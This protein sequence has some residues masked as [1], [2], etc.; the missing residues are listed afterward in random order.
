MAIGKPPI[1]ILSEALCVCS[2]FLW[3][4][5]SSWAAESPPEGQKDPISLSSLLKAASAQ[6]GQIQE[7]LQDIEIARGQLARAKAA[8]FPKASALVLAAPIFE[9]KGNA[10]ASTSNYSTW[11]P[12]IKG[13]I[14]IAQPLYTFGQISSYRK[15][16]EHQIDARVELASAKKNEILAQTKE[17]Y[18]GYLMATELDELVADLS[19]FLGE[20]V[21]TAEK[22][23]KKK[24]TNVKPHDV[25][26]L[27]TALDDLEQKGLYAKQARKTAQRALAWLSTLSI[28]EIPDRKLRP[29][30]F[31]KKTLEE[32][33]AL[34]QKN[35]PEFAALRAGN[36]ARLALKD[37]KQAQSYPVIFLG[38]LA[39]YS[40]SPVREKQNSIFANDPFNRFEGGIG[41]GLKLD[42]EFARHSAEAAEESAEAMKLKATESY[43]A[44]GIELQVK[45]SF[46]ELEQAVE[47]LVVADRR[48]KTS[49]KWFVSNA[50]GWSIGITAAKDLL[51]ALEGDGLA[52]K[53][54]IETVYSLNLALAKLSLAIGQEVTELKY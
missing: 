16:A 30:T 32:Y 26:R 44:P 51:E 17:I 24:K 45:K 11:G 23:L 39:G 31:Q 50:M 4:T 6:N 46:W 9:E 20:A 13:G 15:A 22:S 19:K 47:G 12:L 18:Y 41:L 33:V 8:L 10:L 53:N 27:K 29:E 2:L 54:Y 25:Y 42:L 14:E 49:K 48:R 7:A 21:E 28:S 40:W 52:K 5:P 34:A 43:A 38:A 36:Q 1:F 3:S 37:A 35:R